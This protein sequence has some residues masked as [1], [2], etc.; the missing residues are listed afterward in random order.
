MFEKGKIRKVPAR[1]ELKTHIFELT[2]TS[3]PTCIT[4]RCSVTI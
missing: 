4:V 1:F 3:T 2:P